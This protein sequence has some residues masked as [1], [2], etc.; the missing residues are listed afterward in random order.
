MESKLRLMLILALFLSHIFLL[1]VCFDMIAL[2]F[3]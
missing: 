2:D 1:P 3:H